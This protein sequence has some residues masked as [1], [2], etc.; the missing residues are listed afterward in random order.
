L[1]FDALFTA[2]FIGDVSQMLAFVPITTI[3]LLGILLP[4][5]KFFPREPTSDHSNM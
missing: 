2:V 5:R 3:V 1:V 4:Y